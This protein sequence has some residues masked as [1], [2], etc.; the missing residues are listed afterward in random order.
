ML[1]Q[2]CQEARDAVILI[3]GFLANAYSGRQSD[4]CQTVTLVYTFREGGFIDS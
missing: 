2:I 1:I 3:P 4:E